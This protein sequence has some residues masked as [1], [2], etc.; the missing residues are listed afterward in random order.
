MIPKPDIIPP[1]GFRFREPHD[2][3]L[4][5]PSFDLLIEAIRIHRLNNKYPPGDPRSEA[6]ESIC[7]RWP[8][9]CKHHEI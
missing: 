6:A 5:A 9:Y 2:I 1:G 7:K 3:I 8:T 4:E